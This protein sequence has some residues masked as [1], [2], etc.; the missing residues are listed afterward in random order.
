MAITTRF[1]S[2]S[3]APFVPNDNKMDPSKA[4]AAAVAAGEGAKNVTKALSELA[5][6]ID[7]S[8]EKV[9]D[10][11][12]ARAKADVEVDYNKKYMEASGQIQ[13]GGN[14][15]AQ[16]VQMLQ[17]MAKPYVDN[18]PNDAT[19]NALI[20][21]FI[22]LGKSAQIQGDRLQ[23]NINEKTDLQG[24]VDYASK[25]SALLTLGK[26]GEEKAYAN[27]EEMAAG[28]AGK[29]YDQ[30]KIQK[31]LGDAKDQVYLQ[32]RLTDATKNPFEVLK[33]AQSGA[34][35]DKGMQVQQ[36]I[37]NAATNVIKGQIGQAKSAA[38]QTLEQIYAGK[39]AGDSVSKQLDLMKNLVQ[40]TQDPEL[41][42]KYT[43]LALAQKWDAD[44]RNLSLPELENEL[45]KIEKGKAL[46]NVSPQQAQKFEGVIRNRMEW[47]KK[48]GLAFFELQNPTAIV[49]DLPTPNDPP[50]VIQQKIASRSATA[51]AASEK[52]GM[53]V[54]PVKS[55]E[56]QAVF[57][58]WGKLSIAQQ[59]KQLNAFAAFGPEHAPA[60]AELAGKTVAE[61][62]DKSA[63]ALVPALNLMSLNPAA[64]MDILKGTEKLNKKVVSLELQDVKAQKMLNDAFGS[65]YVDDPNKRS[66]YLA[67][68]KAIAANSLASDPSADSETLIKQAL[69]DISGI[70]D[71]EQ[72][73]T[74]YR[75]SPNYKIVPPEYGINEQTMQATLDSITPSVLAAYSNGVPNVEDSKGNRVPVTESDLQDFQFVHVRGGQYKLVAGDST[76]MNEKNQPLLFDMRSYF[77]DNKSKLS[78]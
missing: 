66:Q 56:M 9:D 50:E 17:E 28:L 35:A 25:S 32:S 20:K 69:K 8:E 64:A 15:G 55:A 48:D 3:N 19:R 76:I 1:I 22:G 42:K 29:S 77:R 65:L 16:S 72:S 21:S 6:S 39:P 14:F 78:K 37:V 43:E 49:G 12:A 45:F 68:A 58:N 47:A 2:T 36:H 40:Q 4:S 60:I 57:Q 26:V 18:A 30:Q 23:F 53:P 75:N 11:Y 33:A 24:L 71:V 51:A 46:G 5:V 38:D 13:S 63:E 31:I 59:E 74:W 44:T 62:K 10:F 52:M 41:T 54:A 34:Y 73:T 27:L 7:A 61:M 70:V 67:A